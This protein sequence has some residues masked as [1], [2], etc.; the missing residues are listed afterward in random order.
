MEDTI[1]RLEAA[2]YHLKF[3]LSLHKRVMDRNP[4]EFSESFK[5]GQKLIF[6]HVFEDIAVIEKNID[7]LKEE[8]K[9]ESTT[10]V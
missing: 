4:R 6:E 7:Q 2:V 9:N 8:L 3:Q 1:R 5:L 10:A